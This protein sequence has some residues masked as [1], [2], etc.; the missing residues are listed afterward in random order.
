MEIK[1]TDKPEFYDD[2]FGVFYDGEFYE[3]VD[4]GAETAAVNNSEIYK[5]IERLREEVSNLKSQPAAAPVPK[6]FVKKEQKPVVP[7]KAHYLAK[8]IAN[9]MI[10]D[11]MLSEIA[12]KDLTRAQRD[13]IINKLVPGAKRLDDQPKDIMKIADTLVVGKMQ[14][15][16]KQYEKMMKQRDKEIKKQQREE[17]ARIAAEKKA[18]YAE[19]KQ[20]GKFAEKVRV[21]ERKQ[22]VEQRAAARKEAAAAKDAGNK[23][24]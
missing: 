22:A 20:D 15:I 23:K 7:P 19:G 21:A 3:E 10:M 18:A 9:R 12:D 8:V 13:G 1:K 16:N 14:R 17:A 5:E 4:D 2:E 6:P 11:S 24:K